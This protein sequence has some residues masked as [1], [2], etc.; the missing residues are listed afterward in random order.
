MSRDLPDRWSLAARGRCGV[1]APSLELPRQCA[2]PRRAQR[3]VCARK[4]CPPPPSPAPGK[5]ITPRE[6]DPSMT[7]PRDAPLEVP[8]LTGHRRADQSF[9]EG[10]CDEL[11]QVTRRQNFWV[12]PAVARSAL[13]SLHVRIFAERP[14][15]GL[16]G[17]DQA[18]N[19]LEVGRC[20]RPTRVSSRAFRAIHARFTR[21][22]P[23]SSLCSLMPVGRRR[24][25]PV[26]DQVACLRF[27]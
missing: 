5:K 23:V 21:A 20:V 11:T 4:T 6:I 10:E 22:C 24:F 8:T 26:A 7:R 9:I 17:L 16:V 19:L 3:W 25:D 27:V 13:P 1:G 18:D 12:Q 2:R 15:L 14:A